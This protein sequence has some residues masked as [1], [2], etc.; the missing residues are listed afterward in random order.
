M[1][2][3]KMCHVMKNFITTALASACLVASTPLALAQDTEPTPGDAA[4][5][6][7]SLVLGHRE[8][9]IAGA[10]LKEI[11]ARL[12]FLLDVGLNYLTLDRG[13]S[14]LSGGEAQRLRQNLVDHRRL[15][16]A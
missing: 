14:T 1:H 11:Q 7:D 10:V 6:L 9:T 15:T 13:A 5:F 3:L 16:G 8:E 4:E 12:R 2:G